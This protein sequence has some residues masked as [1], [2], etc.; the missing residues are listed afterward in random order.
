MKDVADSCSL[1]ANGSTST[2]AGEPAA[3]AAFAGRTRRNVDT[4]AGDDGRRN[5]LYF[6]LLDHVGPTKTQSVA[7]LIP[8]FA[9]LAVVKRGCNILRSLP[10]SIWYASRT[11][12]TRLRTRRLDTQHLNGSIVR[13]RQPE[14]EKEF[15]SGIE[16]DDEPHYCT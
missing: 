11:G 7:F 1:R 13:L 6:Y 2:D 10:R 4:G 12:W 8:V 3:H 5:L 15:A 14:A 16:S 9:L